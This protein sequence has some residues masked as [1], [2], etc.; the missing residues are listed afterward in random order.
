MIAPQVPDSIIYIGVLSGA[1]K[2]AVRAV[3]YPLP[4]EGSGIKL[5]HPT[6]F[7]PATFG[8]GIRCSDPTELRVQG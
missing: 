8:I 4:V 6:G 5:V 3:P 7:E 1:Q 2:D